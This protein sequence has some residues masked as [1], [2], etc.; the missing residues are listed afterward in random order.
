MSGFVANGTPGA[1]AEI[2][3]GDFWPAIDPV[4]IR[5]SMRLDGAISED[6]L[7]ASLIAAIIEVNDDLDAW[8]LEKGAGFAT[9]ADV[10]APQ[11]DQQSRLVLL[12]KRAVACATAAEVTERYRSYDATN[13]AQQRADDMTPSIDE[14][15]RDLRRAVRDF[16]G[17][18]RVT[19]ELI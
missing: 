13:T 15:R 3:S 2:T 7:R 8:R 16:L 17:V 1:E 6:R 9:L 11:I 19:V 12:Y 10:P 18:P 5:A 4:E 14:L